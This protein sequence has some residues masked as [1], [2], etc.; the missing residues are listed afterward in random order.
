MIKSDAFYFI[1]F[2]AKVSEYFAVFYESVVNNFV[3]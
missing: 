3:T 1:Y 2:Y